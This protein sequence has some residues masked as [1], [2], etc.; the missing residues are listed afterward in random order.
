MG[1][2]SGIDD[3]VFR[4]GQMFRFGSL[5]FITDILG[6]ISLHDSGSNQSGRDGIYPVRLTE[7]GQDLPQDFSPWDG[8]KPLGRDHQDLISFVKFCSR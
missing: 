2:T 3:F 8:F 1:S 5:D 7:L 4:P 6:K